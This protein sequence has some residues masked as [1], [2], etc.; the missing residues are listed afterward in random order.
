MTRDYA[1]QKRNIQFQIGDRPHSLTLQNNMVK[2][3][4]N[5]QSAQKDILH[6]DPKKHLTFEITDIT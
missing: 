3:I 6:N 1:G 4:K 5:V 2:K